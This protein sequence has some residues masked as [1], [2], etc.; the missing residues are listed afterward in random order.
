MSCTGNDDLET[1]GM[2]RI[3][4]TGTRFVEAYCTAPVCTPSRASMLTGRFPHV[5]GVTDNGE[6]LPDRYHRQSLG[7]LLTAAGYDCG[8]AGKWHLPSG[9]LD[10]GHGFERVSGFGDEGLVDDCLQFLARE[11]DAP[12]LLAASFDDPHNICEYARGQ[13]L[14][15][16]E[17]PEPPT[18]ACPSLP[19]NFAI[20]PFEPEPIRTSMAAEQ[21]TLGAMSDATPADWRHYRNAY[22]RLIERVDA[23][24]DRLLDGL[25]DREL[26]SNTLVVFLSDHGDGAGAHQVNQKWLLYEE[27]T[28]VPLLIRPPDDEE[29]ALRGHVNEHLVSS[30]LDLLPTLCAAAGITPP[31]DL[32]GRNLLTLA[33]GHSPTDWRPYVVTETEYPMP[34]RMVRTP[35]FKY[36]V[37]AR[38]HHR[39]Q[40]FD[41]TTDRG[42]LVDR[43]VDASYHDIL[44]EHRLQLLRWSRQTNDVFADRGTRHGAP[45]IPGFDLGDVQAY[46]NGGPEP[47]PS[48]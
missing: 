25:S 45:L 3:A 35:Y 20:P 11:R 23:R 15:W 9:D 46:M 28:R 27:P 6:A 48:V 8:W 21:R 40:L 43:S 22:F 17:L 26:E 47:S 2:D 4:A 24:V 41:M 44:V 1:P 33:T 31:D 39:E 5:T 19:A 36:N 42:E 13:N 34:G 32:R 38:G 16:G 37:Y 14:P 30:G 10:E 7:R 18:E 29:S 12:F